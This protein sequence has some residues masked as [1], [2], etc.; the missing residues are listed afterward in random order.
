LTL[1]N[2]WS[3]SLFLPLTYLIFLVSLTFYLIPIFYNY[4]TKNTFFIVS[5]FEINALFYTP[6]VL[7]LSLICLWSSP[8]ISLWFGHLVYTSFQYKITIL[9]LLTFIIFF[10]LYSNVSYV[11]SRE[12]CDYVITNFNFLYWVVLLF[13][14]NSLFTVIFIIEILSTLIFLLLLTFVFS[15]T[16][17]YKNV[18]FSSH[19]SFESSTPFTFIQ[20]ILFFFWISLL[21]SLNLFLFLIFL[22]DKMFSF[23]WYLMEYIFSYFISVSSYKDIYVLGLTWFFI[24]FSIFLKCGI[25]PFYIW[26]G[27]FSLFFILCETFFIKTF[28]AVSSILNSLLVL[29]C[30]S[31]PHIIDLLFF[32]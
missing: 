15:S 16:F 5:S 17:F 19:S 1:S 18:D 2:F 8:S 11:S 21:A 7:I 4:N 27:L 29:L 26:L 9:I 14:S 3:F 13:Y 12:I 25:A 20:S 30:I 28:L 6:C 22:Y 31:S 32:L 23:D 24:L 10:Y